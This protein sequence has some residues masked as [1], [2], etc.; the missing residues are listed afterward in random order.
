MRTSRL[1]RRV[2]AYLVPWRAETLGT[3]VLCQPLLL[4]GQSRLLRLLQGIALSALTWPLLHLEPLLA[5]VGLSASTLRRSRAS[6]RAVCLTVGRCRSPAT[7]WVILSLFPPASRARGGVH[8]FGEAA[9]ICKA[10]AAAIPNAL[11]SSVGK[12]RLAGSTRLIGYRL[13]SQFRLH[14][15]FMALCPMSGAAQELVLASDRHLGEIAW[16]E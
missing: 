7:L 3:R 11:L 2:T 8:K 15:R 10:D 9:C 16:T 13:N 14:R 5:M 1:G 6:Y 12:L 4:S